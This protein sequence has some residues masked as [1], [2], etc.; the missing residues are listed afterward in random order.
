MVVLGTVEL[1]DV[2]SS[3]APEAKRLTEGDSLSV[4]SFA[5]SP[6]G[7]RIAFSAQKD[8]DIISAYSND[9]YVVQL[10]DKVVKKIVDTPGPDTN[11]KGSTD[12]EKTAFQPGAGSK[13]FY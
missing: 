10:A 8:S 7:T 5:W 11:P 13:D 12:G 9:I 2:S 4:G 3:V 6:D 1:P